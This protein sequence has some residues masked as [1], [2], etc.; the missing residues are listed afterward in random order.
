MIRLRLSRSV[1]VTRVT[2]LLGLLPA[3]LL[4][5]G[6]TANPDVFEGAP[7]G[8]ADGAVTGTGTSPTGTAS[9]SGTGTTTLPDGA[10]VTNAGTPGPL[11]AGVVADA[12]PGG[13]TS[14][15]TCGTASCAIPSQ[16][17]CSTRAQG[18]ASFQFSCVTGAA[19]PVPD[20]GPGSGGGGGRPTTLKC[21]SNANCAANEVCCITQNNNTTGSSCMTQAA[22]DGAPG[23]TAVLCDPANPAVGCPAA[24]PCSSDNINDWR[25]PPGFGTCGGVGN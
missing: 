25:L 9:D 13:N 5:C 21:T 23:D 18:G 16:V 19:C 22:C 4:A 8:S 6:T 1:P 20:A 11:D 12:G 14:S 24:D 15:L 17:C 2:A 7:D 3:L 10:V